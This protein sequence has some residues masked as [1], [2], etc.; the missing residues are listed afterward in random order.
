MA[1]NSDSQGWIAVGKKNKREKPVQPTP[2]RRKPLPPAEE[3]RECFVCHEKGHLKSQCP[4]RA[5]RNGGKNEKSAVSQAQDTPKPRNEPDAEAP[6]TVVAPP[7]EPRKK[8]VTPAAPSAPPKPAS[9]SV[10]PWARPSS[11]ADSK[12]SGAPAAASSA[13][14]SAER[15]KVDAPKKGGVAKKDTKSTPTSGGRSDKKTSASTA[16]A[17]PAS[18]ALANGPAVA[19][20][21]VSAWSSRAASASA[22]TPPAGT[23]A[24]AKGKAPAR[25]VAGGS[26]SAGGGGGA[27]AV[28]TP[29]PRA[30]HV[31]AKKTALSASAEAY[32][33][34]AYQTAVARQ[35]QSAPAADPVEIEF[36]G[37]EARTG[38]KFVGH[39]P[40]KGLVVTSDARDRNG[41]RPIV[42]GFD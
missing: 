21:P 35:A 6:V 37:G 5:T 40:V 15:P 42:F 31:P 2:V 23:T 41:K 32:V 22:R 24:A 12:A 17:E 4:V 26:G 7:P 33:P 10:A 13:P 38:S 39:P 18:A 19:V 36:G 9:Q 14:A 34:A 25:A 28:A 3:E 27:A 29:A 16:T 11:S 1:S 20:P 8:G 30:A